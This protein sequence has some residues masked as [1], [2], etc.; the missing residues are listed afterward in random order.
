LFFGGRRHDGERTGRSEGSRLPRWAK[1]VASVL[2]VLVIGAMAFAIFQ[3]IKVLPRI[4]LAPGYAFVDQRGERFVSEDT[5]SRITV[6]SFIP[7]VCDDGCDEVFATMREVATRLPAEVDL[8]ELEV[9]YVTVVEDPADTATLA[10]L[11]A[12]AGADGESWRLV[13]GTE[14]QLETVVGLGFRHVRD[15]TSTNPHYVVVDG[16][17][18]IRGDYRYRTEASDAD[19]LVRHVG[20]LVS[21]VNHAS[22]V[23][24]FA[25]GAAH[26]FMCYP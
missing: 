2:V 19:K 4:R 16:W 10:A 21:E 15:R 3:P 13:T 1:V 22:G 24:S 9:E 14:T 18:M 17:G 12:S 8:G 26:V 23:A 5:R 20:L 7:A 6:Y 25:Y 11:A